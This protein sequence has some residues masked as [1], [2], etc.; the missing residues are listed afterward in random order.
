MSVPLELLLKFEPSL[1][2]H[3]LVSITNQAFKHNHN[4]LSLYCVFRHRISRFPAT[5]TVQSYDSSGLLISFFIANRSYKY[6]FPSKFTPDNSY[7]FDT[8]V[9]HRLPSPLPQ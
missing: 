9:L 3:T 7:T 2:N 6:F 1:N 4:R 5:V 8:P